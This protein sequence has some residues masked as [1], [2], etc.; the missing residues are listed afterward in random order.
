[1]RVTAPAGFRASGV[2]AGLKSIGGKDVATGTTKPAAMPHDREHVLADVH[3]AG[4][5]E[6][7]RAI[8]ASA[9]AW[10]D[11]SRT[12]WEERAALQ[13]FTRARA[14]FFTVGSWQIHLRGCF[15]FCN[16]CFERILLTFLGEMAS[17]VATRAIF[18]SSSR[19]T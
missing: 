4:A 5:A 8:K 6:V 11:W 17:R 10:Q 2:A 18:L 12:S 9:D 19:Q 1:M 14:A 15:G 3:Q 13:I 16:P 7:E